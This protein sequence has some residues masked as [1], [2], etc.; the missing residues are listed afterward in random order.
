VEIGGGLGRTAYFADLFGVTDYTI[1]D[2]PVTNAAQGY[3]IGRTLGPDAVTLH[4]EVPAATRRV[5]P[6]QAFPELG[7]DVDLVVTVDSL[8]ELARETAER[9]VQLAATRARRLLSINHEVNAFT[10]RSLFTATADARVT[11]FPYWVRRGYVEE[12]VEWR[13]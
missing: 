2:I 11:R 13:T 3:F 6:P 1:V 8:T 4:G 10:A 9:Y 7:D 5:V 12:L